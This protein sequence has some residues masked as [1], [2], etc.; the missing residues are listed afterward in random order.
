MAK[1]LREAAHQI[2]REEEGEED[3]AHPDAK[4]GAGYLVAGVP[5]AAASANAIPCVLFAAN[6]AAKLRWHQAG[7]FE[8]GP[9]CHAY[10]GA[11]LHLHPSTV[12]APK[13]HISPAEGNWQVGAPSPNTAV[14]QS[15]AGVAP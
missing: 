1:R 6:A 5:A 10:A 2:L 11:A 12:D 3:A 8:H 4:R 7:Y 9:S 15:A 13:P 14:R